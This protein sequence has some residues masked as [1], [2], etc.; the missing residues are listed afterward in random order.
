MA[1]NILQDVDYQKSAAETLQ[2]CFDAGLVDQKDKHFVT[3]LLTQYKNKGQLSVKQW[4]WIEKMMIR[5]MGVDELSVEPETVDLSPA[6]LFTLFAHVKEKLKSPSLVFVLL[7]KND[8]HKEIKIY[9]K[10]SNLNVVWAHQY[11][12]YLGTIY[13][14]GKLTFTKYADEKTQSHLTNLLK[15]ICTNPQKAVASHGKLMNK[16][17][18]CNKTLTDPTSVKLGYGPVCAHN[19]HMPYGYDAAMSVAHEDLIHGKH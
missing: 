12:G 11:P 13:P 17:C 16:C 15:E 3:S 18:F 8:Q 6:P 9:P 4:P 5:A 1:Q 10:G 19:W 14:S 2:R 7:R